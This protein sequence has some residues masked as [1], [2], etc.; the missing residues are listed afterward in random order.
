MNRRHSLYALVC[1]GLVGLTA[2]AMGQPSNRI[3]L[4]QLELMFDDMR[5]KTNWNVDGP[6][7]WGYFFVD[8]SREKLSKAAERL[9]TDGYSIVEIRKVPES[10]VMHQ[11][12]AERVEAHSPESLHARNSKLYELAAELGLASYDG[13]DVGPVAV[14]TK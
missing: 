10:A 6:L 9:R 3:P 14:R 5:K 13:M 12:H 2:T 1:T 7:L 8:P 11:L 4:A